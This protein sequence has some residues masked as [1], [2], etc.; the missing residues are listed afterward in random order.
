MKATPYFS[1]S[2]CFVCSNDPSKVARRILCVFSEQKPSIARSNR[3]E[4][5]W[6][7]LT[8]YKL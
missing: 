5:A 8:V 7:Q 3:D 4:L 6:N 1:F 2:R